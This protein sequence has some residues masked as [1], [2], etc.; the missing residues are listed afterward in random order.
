MRVLEVT[1]RKRPIH[2]GLRAALFKDQTI[3]SGLALPKTRLRAAD[4]TSSTA[5]QGQHGNAVFWQRETRSS[6]GGPEALVNRVSQSALPASPLFI[7]VPEAPSRK[8]PLHAGF[9]GGALN[10]L[11]SGSTL[12][13]DKAASR[14]QYEEYGKASQRRVLAKE[15]AI[16]ERRGTAWR[17]QGLDCLSAAS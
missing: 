11:Y 8:R 12:P 14:R 16:S 4:S 13:K 9:Q 6:E 7:R 1:A 15:A 17:K 3:Y 5:M 10:P 2:T